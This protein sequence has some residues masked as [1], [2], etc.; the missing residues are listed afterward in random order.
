MHLC[1]HVCPDEAAVRRRCL[2]QEKGALPTAAAA[3]AAE[4][5]AEN[6]LFLAELDDENTDNYVI[7][8]DTGRY[9]RGTERL[10]DTANGLLGGEE[11]ESGKRFCAGVFAKRGRRGN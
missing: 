11:E 6:G 2:T 10:E 3:A 8:M 9:H 5:D 1:F 7:D 4:I